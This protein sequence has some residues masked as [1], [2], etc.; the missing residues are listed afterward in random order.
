MSVCVLVVGIS[1]KRAAEGLQYNITYILL[2]LY[3][4]I[5]ARHT[6]NCIL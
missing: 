5:R 4:R 1:C 2:L 6:R 3:Y